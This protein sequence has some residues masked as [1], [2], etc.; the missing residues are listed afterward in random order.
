VKRGG[1]PALAL[2]AVLLSACAPPAPEPPPQDLPKLTLGESLVLT[3]SPELPQEAVLHLAEGEAALLVVDQTHV[4]AMVD[5]FSPRG[6]L[7]LHFDSPAATEAPERV[8]LIAESDGAY[9]LQFQP[10]VGEGEISVLVERLRP[11][12]EQDQRCAAAGRALMDQDFPAAAEAAEAAGEWGTA[13]VALKE[14]GL[15]LVSEGRIPDAQ[16]TYRRALPLAE[17][18]GVPRLEVSLLNL[19]GEAATT[20]GEGEE[21]RDH[22][23]EA[24]HRASRA[25]YLDGEAVT[26]NNLGRVAEARELAHRAIGF[27]HQAL[28][29]W[30][31]AHSPRAAIALTNL[32]SSHLLL[33]RYTEAEDFL[34]EALKIAREHGLAE[35]EAG[36]LA[37][38]GWSAFRQGQTVEAIEL[39]EE[40]LALRRQREDRPSQMGILDRLGTVL[41]RAGRYG[42]AQSRY[43]AALALLEESAPNPRFEATI[44]INLG[45]TL[46]RAGRPDG[47][48]QAEALFERADRLLATHAN[49]GSA[50]YRHYC[51]GRIERAR[52]NLSAAREAVEATLGIVDE[53]RREARRGGT[54]HRALEVWQDYAELHIAVLVDLHRQTGDRAFLHRAFEAADERRVRSF[55]ETLVEEALYPRQGMD[56][57]LLTRYEAM[58]ARLQEV[59][60]ALLSA[61]PEARPAL[62]RESRR[63]LLEMAAVEDR[64]RA[65]QPPGSTVAR[66]EPVPLEVV[67]ALLAP[68]DVL[69]SYSLGAE[70]SFLFALTPDALH[71]YELPPRP[72]LESLARQ[73]HGHL[74][75]SAFGEDWK[76]ARREMAALQ[77]H[78]LAPAQSLLLP[79]EAPAPGRLLVIAEG[80]LLY[81]PFNALPG[82]SREPLLESL[83]IV[84]LPSAAV[85]KALADRTAARTPAPFEL[86]ALGDAAF[87]P[88]D[89]RV[90]TGGAAVRSTP[91]G[92][93]LKRLFHS[94]REARAILA[95]VAP[96]DRLEALGFHATRDLLLDP[97]LSLYRRLHIA[98][99]AEIRD[100]IPEL[101]EVIL[102]Q[103]NARGEPIP[104]RVRLHEI[105]PL[106]FQ[107]DLVVLSACSTAL[108]K[109]LRGDGMLSFTRAFL[110]AG[111]AR[112]LVTL[113]DVDD[114]ATA[115]LMIRFYEAH[116]NRG[117]PPAT[118]LREAQR[119]IRQQPGWEA[120]YYWAGFVLQGEP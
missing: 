94:G 102:S 2:A 120:P 57:T 9:R 16:D 29:L 103:V 19:L 30:Q 15:A 97:R 83:E 52:G 91:P 5:I 28:G 25:G 101:S 114:P 45:C 51:Q 113:W 71:L 53:V 24:L 90:D 85:W 110:T 92:R 20:L 3:L 104:G 47:A 54:R 69:L 106:H 11:A 105:Y 118:A 86:A 39:L 64:A 76:H 63:L 59:A 95:L 62:E 44:L 33:E 58:R 72:V 84:H 117:L 38:L 27:Y 55:Y 93:P 10:F 82:L 115:D 116:L 31:G 108:G 73:A 43:E 34:Q 14:W 17:R 75:R 109:P 36:A 50:A 79:T 78:L 23:G 87:G 35:V 88:A 46:E 1:L 12:T 112:V 56:S 22:L 89:D 100:D 96:G 65:S 107:A 111:A 32:G 49:P 74:R 77:R 13:A 41:Y 4:D 37:Q 70:V 21:A 8:C 40:A 18:G 42:E 48:H 67:Q 7:V 66:P 99:H 68:G 26:L 119:W 80:A 61:E 98:T 60:D 6:K 81:L